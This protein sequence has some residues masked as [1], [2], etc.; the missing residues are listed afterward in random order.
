[1]CVIE[2][3]FV[4][5][6][7]DPASPDE[8]NSE[9]GDGIKSSVE[10]CDDGN[11]ENDD[12]CSQD[13]VLETSGFACLPLPC[14]QTTC[15]D[16]SAITTCDEVVGLLMTQ[17]ESGRAKTVWS[18]PALPVVS[19]FEVE[20]SYSF[21]GTSVSLTENV[22]LESCPEFMCETYSTDNLMPG[23]SLTCSVRALVEPYCWSDWKVA[24]ILIVGPPSRPLNP[25][26][27]QGSTMD[28]CLS[29][30][31]LA[32]SDPDDHGD[33]RPPGSLEQAELTAFSVQ[34]FC[35]G[36]QALL[37]IGNVKT[38][39]LQAVWE[40]GDASRD[41]AQ[42]SIPQAFSLKSPEFPDFSLRCLRGQTV[43]AQV[44][45]HNVLFHGEW[46]SSVSKRAIGLPSPVAALQVIE[47]PDGLQV[48]W[49]EVRDFSDS[50]L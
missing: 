2:C 16:V 11:A 22:T 28:P 18:H 48:L 6:H 33:T 41:C 5:N 10:D 1:M 3:G 15:Q 13:C 24:S 14:K 39:G 49:Q 26:I 23:L 32:W 21:D 8:C 4:C 34:M 17:T 30:W 19:V 47:L 45:A 29:V 43:S 7:Q 38:V 9:C 50:N 44:R 42:V 25:I 12:G 31:S 36:K 37:K 27:S 20:C 40:C 46:S 35:G